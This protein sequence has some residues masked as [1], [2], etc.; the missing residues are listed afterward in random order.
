MIIYVF[1]RV[2]RKN[3]HPEE[4]EYIPLEDGD[5]ESMNINK[6]FQYKEFI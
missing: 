1:D 3:Y 4:L 5:M 2:R 6:F